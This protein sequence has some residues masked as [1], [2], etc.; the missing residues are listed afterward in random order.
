M[1]SLT[2]TFSPFQWSELGPH[3]QKGILFLLQN[4]MKYC[5]F[6]HIKASLSINVTCEDSLF[7]KTTA[8]ARREGSHTRVCSFCSMPLS[9]PWQPPGFAHDSPQLGTTHS[10]C[11]NGDSCVLSSTR[12]MVAAHTKLLGGTAKTLTSLDSMGNVPLI[13]TRLNF[14]LC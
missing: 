2:L 5:S 8:A 13:P 10:P 14:T 1:L 11:R 12:V 4:I 9:T 6:R 3:T 7:I